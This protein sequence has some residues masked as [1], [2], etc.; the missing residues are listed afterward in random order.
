M[1]QPHLEAGPHEQD[2]VGV[3]E[4]LQDANLMPKLLPH[5]LCVGFTQLFYSNIGDPIMH[6]FVHLQEITGVSVCANKRPLITGRWEG[7]KE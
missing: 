6:A 2:D 3:A 7:E 5:R 4:T 1:R